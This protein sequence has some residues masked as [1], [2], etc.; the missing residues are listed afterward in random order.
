MADRV[1]MVTV[2]RARKIALVLPGEK[3]L[4]ERERDVLKG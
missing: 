2:A 1:P 4:T 3:P